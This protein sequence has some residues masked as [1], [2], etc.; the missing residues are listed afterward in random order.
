MA[1][2]RRF[3]AKEFID[4]VG[5]SSPE[6]T[7]KE[8]NF[9]KRALNLPADS[10]VLD[11]CCGFGRLTKELADSTGW[12]M[13][14]FDL[15][16]DY[17]AIARTEFSA[18]KIEYC[19][20]DMRSLPFEKCFDGVINM[21]TSF[22]FFESDEENEVVVQQ[23]CKSL[24]PRGVFLL[25]YEN[26]INFINNEVLRK[27]HDWKAGANGRYYLFENEYDLMNEREIFKVIVLENGEACETI[28]YNIRLY[29][30]PEI[31]QMLSRNGFSVVDVWGDY[32]GR[33]YSVESR[34]LITLSRKL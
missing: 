24:K 23:V 11:L 2:Y 7:Q 6:Q 32:D 21:F 31:K 30:L 27:Q 10:T 29:S 4:L 1:W 5:F 18:P 26:K 19:Q 9:V 28:G 33:T 14:G 20:G 22:G 25:D 34:R 17:L 8:A 12:Q 13:T 16:E 15:S 3:Y